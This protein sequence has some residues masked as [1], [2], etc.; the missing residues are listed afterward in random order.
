[1]RQQ[2]CKKKEVK[3]LQA[4]ARRSLFF[5]FFFWKIEDTEMFLRF[6]ESDLVRTK[7]CPLWYRTITTGQGDSCSCKRD[8]GM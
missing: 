7:S 2:R 4:T 3:V 6:T 1:M 8:L 5:F